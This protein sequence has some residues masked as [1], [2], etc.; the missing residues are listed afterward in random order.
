MNIVIN[1]PNVVVL[2]DLAHENPPLDYPAEGD[3]RK[4][5]TS[6]R[7]TFYETILI[8]RANVLSLSFY[9]KDNRVLYARL[10]CL[11]A[12]NAAIAVI[13]CWYPFSSNVLSTYQSQKGKLGKITDLHM[14]A[15]VYVPMTSS[16]MFLI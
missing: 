10:Y 12:S 16:W 3:D 1:L 15:N 13:G 11:N 7:L 4:G 8:L 2:G 5:K 9:N 6:L 14:R